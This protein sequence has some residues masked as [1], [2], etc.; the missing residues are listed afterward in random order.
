MNETGGIAPEL[1]FCALRCAL[2]SLMNH[3]DCAGPARSSSE[4]QLGSSRKTRSR[5]SAIWQR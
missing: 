2:S 5:S 4:A 3:R 1:E